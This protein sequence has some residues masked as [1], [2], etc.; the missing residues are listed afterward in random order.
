M[1]PFTANTAMTKNSKTIEVPTSTMTFMEVADYI[2]SAKKV[3]DLLNHSSD[4]VMLSEL[5]TKQV[6]IYKWNKKLE[7]VGIPVKFVDWRRTRRTSDSKKESNSDFDWS[8][9]NYEEKFESQFEKLGTAGKDFVKRIK[10]AME[11][12]KNS[13]SEFYF[14]T[15]LTFKGQ[16]VNVKVS[17]TQQKSEI[18]V[19]LT[20]KKGKKS[21]AELT[22]APVTNGLC[23]K[24]E[25][26]INH[27]DLE[28]SGNTKFHYDWTDLGFAVD[29]LKELIPQIE[30]IFSAE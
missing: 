13:S 25:W 14:Y 29:Q 24:A 7:E 3:S 5:D 18:E 28:C 16:K 15:N 26:Y 19:T 9:F 22:I 10:S 17:S 1:T 11:F 30:K 2:R 20:D 8:K 12:Y 4:L 6:P 23:I 21:T 27:G